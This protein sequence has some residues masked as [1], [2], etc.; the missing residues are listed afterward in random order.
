MPC[1]PVYLEF[2]VKVSADVLLL[3]W[4]RTTPRLIKELSTV[5]VQLSGSVTSTERGLSNTW[6]DKPWLKWCSLKKNKNKKNYNKHWIRI[7]SFQLKFAAS[8][9]A[10]QSTSRS[11]T[12]SLQKAATNLERFLRLGARQA[13]TDE[14]VV[15]TAAREEKQARKCKCT[16]Y[17]RD[18]I[19]SG[20]F[21]RGRVKKG[22]ETDSFKRWFTVSKGE[23]RLY[24]M[25]K[26]TQSKVEVGGRE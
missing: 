10:S 7:I 17:I 20:T 5:W 3:V 23:S 21:P 9:V 6:P 26:K 15:G 4:R 13:V 19:L 2:Y 16:S 25:F 22:I 8:K 12:P 14:L 11:Q 18:L 1:S 24:E